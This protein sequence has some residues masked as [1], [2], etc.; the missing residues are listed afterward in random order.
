M[1]YHAP[2]FGPGLASARFNAG[3]HEQ[4]AKRQLGWALQPT[5]LEKDQF[6][7]QLLF[8]TRRQ[9]LVVFAVP[10]EVTTEA[11]RRCKSRY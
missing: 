6:P 5:L 10:F 3:P 4:G 1:L 11:G 7:H 2:F 8:Q 9:L